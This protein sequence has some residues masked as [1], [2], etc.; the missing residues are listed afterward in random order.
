MDGMAENPVRT[1]LSQ[2]ELRALYQMAQSA[3]F[4]DQNQQPMGT[5]FD[6][7]SDQ[8]EAVDEYGL[9]FDPEDYYNAAPATFEEEANALWIVTMSLHYA[10]TRFNRHSPNYFTCITELE[11]NI[12]QLGSYCITKEVLEKSGVE[13]THLDGLSINELYCMASLHFR[14][15]E[16]AFDDQQN[17]DIGLDMNVVRWIFRWASLLDRLRATE[18]KIEKIQNGE[19]KAESLLKQGQTY[20]DGPKMRRDSSSRALGP[21]GKARSLSVMKSFANEV[22]KE[23]IEQAKLSERRTREQERAR[24][25]LEKR[26]FYSRQREDD[27]DLDD[28]FRGMGAFGPPRPFQPEKIPEVGMTGTQLGKYLIDE[29]IARGDFAEADRIRQESTEQHIERWFRLREPGGQ[30]SGVRDQRAGPS[31][32]TRKKR[33]K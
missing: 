30:V 14:K 23:S 5:A 33:K 7:D 27:F 8:G 26:G 4:D 6:A 24:R 32:E 18:E 17:S 9:P 22:K 20:S 16:M 29:A 11:K 15:C 25:R 1:E 19:I 2:E 3:G 13:F 28:D 10:A 31:D 21:V 12:K